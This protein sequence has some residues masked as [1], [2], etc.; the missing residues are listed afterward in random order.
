VYIASISPSKWD[1]WREDCVV[2]QADIYD[3]LVLLTESPTAKKT[4]WEETSTLHVAYGPMIERIKHLMSH[5]LLV[6]MLLHDFL[7]RHIAP[8]RGRARPA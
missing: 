2:I 7:S 4:A 1:R 6:M 3:C 8:L 5:D